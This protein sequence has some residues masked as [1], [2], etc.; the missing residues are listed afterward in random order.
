MI[1]KAIILA[2]GRG[3]RLQPLTSDIPKPMIPL[4]GKPVMEY[5]VEHLASQGVREIMVNTSHLAHRIEQYFGDGRR[6]GVSIGYSFEGHLD[7]D[8]LVPEPV[9]SAGALRKI[10]DHGGFI[11]GTTAVLCGDAV[12]NLDLQGAAARHRQQ[13]AVATVIAR[14]VALKDVSSYGVVVTDRDGR[15]VSFQEKPSAQDALSRQASTGIYLIEPE[16]LALI[17]ADRPYDIGAELFP[18][19]VDRGM[20]FFSQC[21][22]FDWLD[23]GRVADYWRI[24]QQLMQGCMPGIGL[25]GTVAR[26]GVHVGLNVSVDWSTVRVEGPVYVGSGTRIEPGV[27]LRGPVWIGNGCHVEA[28]AQIERSVVF[29]YAH[30]GAHAVAREV[31]V[32][33]AYCVHRDGQAQGTPSAPWWSDAR[34]RHEVGARSHAYA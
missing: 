1:T 7:G 29:D 5:I 31:I 27:T 26:P 16:A 12:V 11:D 10:Q 32:S 21:L 15:V 13:G 3:T 2:A 9:G 17:P 28:G 18:A 30:V 14:E 6:F 24:V 23:I 4:L 33:G 20:P 34:Q 22:D 25:P 19:L 8:T